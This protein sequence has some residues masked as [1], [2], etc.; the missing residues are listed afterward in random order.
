MLTIYFK[1]IFWVCCTVKPLRENL[2]KPKRKSHY[3]LFKKIYWSAVDLQCCVSLLYFFLVVNVSHFLLSEKCDIIFPLYQE[4]FPF[5][6]LDSFL[7]W[8]YSTLQLSF[9]GN[10]RTFFKRSDLFFHLKKF[11]GPSTWHVGS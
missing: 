9:W 8:Y 4:T 2:K 6:L 1:I 11:S 10:L 5:P 7:P 3:I